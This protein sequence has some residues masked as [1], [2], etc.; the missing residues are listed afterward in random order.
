MDQMDGYEQL[1]L[2]DIFTEELSLWRG[3]TFVEGSANN[4]NSL[5]AGFAR[6]AEEAERYTKQAAENALG[7]I[8]YATRQPRNERDSFSHVMVEWADSS[9]VRPPMIYLLKDTVHW[10]HEML[11]KGRPFFRSSEVT[12]GGR[13]DRQVAAV[14][15]IPEA[16]ANAQIESVIR[17]DPEVRMALA[18]SQAV[19]AQWMAGFSPDGNPALASSARAAF[20]IWRERDDTPIEIAEPTAQAILCILL[21]TRNFGRRYAYVDHSATLTLR[22]SSSATLRAADRIASERRWLNHRK[23]IQYLRRIGLNDLALA[24][25][26]QANAAVRSS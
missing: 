3:A 10:P 1:Q 19:Y 16:F 25:I 24:V 11:V 8:E 9:C 23:A 15:A 7:V 12:A 17:A 21:R 2:I 6:S 20:G 5:W 26:A 4:A 18:E 14:R 13:F 22:P